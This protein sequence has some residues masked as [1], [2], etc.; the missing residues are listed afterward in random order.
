MEMIARTLEEHCSNRAGNN[1]RAEVKLEG[2][3]QA[4]VKVAFPWPPDGVINHQIRFGSAEASEIYRRIFG[5]KRFD[6]ALH[7]LP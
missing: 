6:G 1:W 2:H 3:A 7:C 5:R 4:A